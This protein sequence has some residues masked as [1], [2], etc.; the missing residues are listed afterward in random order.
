MPKHILL[1]IFSFSLIIL[2]W[3]CSDNAAKM[4]V[5][6]SNNKKAEINENAKKELKRTLEAYFQERMKM[7]PFEATAIGIRD[8]DDKLPIDISNSYRNELKNFY[9][10]YAR[11]AASFDENTLDEEDKISLQIFK[12]EMLMNMKALEFDDNLM[13]IN[14]FSCF[15]LTFA[16]IGSGSGIQRFEK[17]EDY[18]NFLSRMDKFPEWCDTAIFNMKKGMKQGVVLPKTLVLKVLPQLQS[19]TEPNIEKHLFYTPI[20]NFKGEILPEQKIALAQKYK[21]AI[22]DKIIPSYKKLY[23]FMSGEYLQK[24]RISSGLSSIPGGAA[25]YN[26]LAEQWTTSNIPVEEIYNTGLTEVARIQAEMD[27]LMKQVGFNGTRKQFLS[28]LNTDKQFFPFKNE[29]EVIAAYQAIYDTIKPYLDKSFNTFPKTKFEIRRTEKFREASASAEYIQ[30]SDDGSRP[31]VFY[32]PIPDVKKYNVIGTEN[33]FLHE[34]I[35]GHHFQI[36]LQQ[37]NVNLPKFRKFAWYGAYGE[38][39]ALYCESLG[40]AMGLYK[41]PYQYL[42]RLSDEMLRAQRLV[43]DVGLH[44]KNLSREKAIEYMLD[45]QLI[46]RAGAEAE[47]ERYMANP[48]QALSYKLGELSILNIKTKFK[49]E[50]QSHYNEAVFHDLV[51][52]NG[53][54]PLSIFENF[55]LKALEN[56]KKKIKK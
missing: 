12:R 15:P 20:L 52:K 33:L 50:L 1:V 11:L 9:G 4:P 31:G 54:L 44:T 29:S 36:S 42:G 43:I 38:G 6:F 26:Y 18:H 7:Y 47:V 39:W 55:M 51:L 2:K 35:P 37:E 40:K 22:T 13:P 19:M 16:Q 17:A 46:S 27:N 21:S 5:S 24:S 34:A 32:V 49:N 28:K 8:Y 25:Y 41:N 30:G 3:S 56:E 14:Q 45:N 23:S 48:A 53:V 10:K